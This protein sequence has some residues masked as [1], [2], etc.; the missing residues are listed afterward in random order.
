MQPQ[1][2]ALAERKPGRT[3]HERNAQRTLVVRDD[4]PRDLR[5]PD[6]RAA[7]LARRSAGRHKRGANLLAARAGL[8]DLGKAELRSGPFQDSFRSF[9]LAWLVLWTV[10]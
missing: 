8:G 1:T 2:D 3:G 10:H 9:S 5:N 4:L 6:E 7:Q